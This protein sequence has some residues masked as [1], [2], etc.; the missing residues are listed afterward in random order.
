MPVKQFNYRRIG[1]GTTTSNMH[2]SIVDGE[3]KN[4]RIYNKPLTEVEV[5][6]IYSKIYTFV[7][8]TLVNGN[9]DL[10]HYYKR[11]N[12]ISYLLSKDNWKSTGSFAGDSND[13]MKSNEENIVDATKTD[14]KPPI[15]EPPCKL[16]FTVSG[17]RS[18]NITLF[19]SKSYFGC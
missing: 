3:I 12:L 14:F 16:I 19:L 1:K 18:I 9:R 15:S 13:R 11:T 7:D 8:S 4:L 5:N 2:I 6:D 10:F 17:D